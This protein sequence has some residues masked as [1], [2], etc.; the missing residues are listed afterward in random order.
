MFS[1]I[2]FTYLIVSFVI[3]MAFVA[4]CK[5]SAQA[6]QISRSRFI[7]YISTL[8]SDESA[9]SDRSELAGHRYLHPNTPS[10]LASE[11]TRA[12]A[13]QSTESAISKGKIPED[14]TSSF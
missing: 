2:I 13:D 5:A 9:D 3:T 14:V 7:D 8:H 6:D 4:L 12:Q 10:V 1:I 11:K